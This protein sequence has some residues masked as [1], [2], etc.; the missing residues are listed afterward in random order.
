MTTLKLTFTAEGGADPFTAT[1]AD[2]NSDGNAMI[3]TIMLTA[4]E[5]YAVTIQVLNELERPTEDVTLE[6]RD[7]LEEHQFFFY[8]DD[9]SSPASESMSAIVNQSYTD[10]D[11][12]GFPVG[13]S[14]TFEAVE[15]GSGQLNIML[16]H[17]P[18]VNGNLVKT[19]ELA[20][21][22]KNG[23]IASLPGAVDID[24]SF[25]ITVQ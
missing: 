14:N 15:A 9:I 3:D 7:E 21:M 2:V 6:L 24:V 18:R 23:D 13:L 1:W 25:P 11:S 5:T 20:E 8:G 16:R 4:G 19:A 12:E 17:M 22:V 10:M